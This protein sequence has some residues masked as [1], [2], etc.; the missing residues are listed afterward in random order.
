MPP[1]L[2]TYYLDRSKQRKY[3][4]RYKRRYF[5]AQNDTH[6]VFS[7][8]FGFR[9]S[10]STFLFLS[11]FLS[12]SS[13]GSISINSKLGTRLLIFLSPSSPHGPRA[14]KGFDPNAKN[15]DQSLKKIE[16]L[17]IILIPINLD[18]KNRRRMQI[19]RCLVYP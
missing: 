2:L 13:S 3:P 7:L 8:F 1:R 14:R 15:T 9:I 5:D 12:M 16:F 18:L 19:L 4:D 10:K 17:Y 6:R 11:L